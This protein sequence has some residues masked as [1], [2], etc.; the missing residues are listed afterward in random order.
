MANLNWPIFLFSIWHIFCRVWVIE[1]L[2][3][4]LSV[5][6]KGLKQSLVCSLTEKLV[7]SLLLA[8]VAESLLISVFETAISTTL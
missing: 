8:K 4:V 3:V 7:H 2:S 6:T 1:M 5:Q